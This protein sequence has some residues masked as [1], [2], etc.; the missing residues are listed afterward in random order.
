MSGDF[1]LK[2]CPDSARI[3][4]RFQQESLSA[5]NKNR[6][7]FSAGITVR[8]PQERVSVLGENMHYA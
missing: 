2:N 7:P 4:V 1:L 5:F 3:T 8:I 6:R